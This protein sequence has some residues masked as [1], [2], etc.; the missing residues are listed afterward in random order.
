MA[1]WKSMF[2]GIC[3]HCP[4]SSSHAYSFRHFPKHQA[5]PVVPDYATST[6]I[7]NL[8]NPEGNPRSIQLFSCHRGCRQPMLAIFHIT[9]SA[10]LNLNRRCRRVYLPISYAS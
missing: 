8:L 3:T 5:I 7:T 1:Q 4:F 2:S 6:R 9:A 10:R